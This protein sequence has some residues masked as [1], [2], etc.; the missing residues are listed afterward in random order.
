MN[1]IVRNLGQQ[2][3]LVSWQAMQQL[4]DSRT[5]DTLDELWIV[6]HPPVY[7]LGLNGKPE[8][9]LNPSTI[10]VI[11]TDRGGQVTYHG[12]GQLVIYVLLDL[13]RKVLGVRALVTALEQSIIIVLKQYGLQAVARA[14][15]PGVYINNQKIASVG[16][17]IRRHCSYHGLSLNVN[18]NLTPFLG[19]N[20]CGQ[21]GLSIT[22]LSDLKG[23]KYPLEVSVPLIH[24]LVQ[25]LD[26]TPI[27][28]PL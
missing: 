18:M 16:L 5:I 3:Y 27:P 21:A 1:I 17:R 20:P 11:Q 15:A 13:K 7:T 10:P 9:V 28:P 2:A 8:H 6:E 26:Y 23:P 19:I 24:A 12:P 22:Q 14:D 4:T 25:Q